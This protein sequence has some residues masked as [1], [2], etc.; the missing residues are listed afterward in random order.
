MGARR[1]CA[2]E[3]A[4]PARPGR[5]IAHAAGAGALACG[6][7]LGGHES[8]RRRSS[9][10]S[11]T[12]PVPS[13]RVPAGPG[14]QAG[15]R[16]RPTRRSSRTL[17]PNWRVSINLLPAVWWRSRLRPRNERNNRPLGARKRCRFHENESRVVGLPRAVSCR[18]ADPKHDFFII[19]RQPQQPPPTTRQTG[20]G[21]G[22]APRSPTLF[23]AGRQ[24]GCLA[25]GR[26]A[27]TLRRRLCAQICITTSRMVA[28]ARPGGG[29]GGAAAAAANET[30]HSA[31]SGGRN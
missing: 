12:D 22:Q 29:R 9:S 25:A 11:S 27:E 30:L 4:G 2:S 19:D 31:R 10:S 15:A 28:T 17:A 16:T 7:I 6:P 8:G 5:A 26:P 18:R 1:C 23:V 21:C 14:R 13:R 20:A 3:R 24:C